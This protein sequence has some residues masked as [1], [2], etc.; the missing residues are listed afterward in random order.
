L[1]SQSSAFVR[2]RFTWLAYLMLAY[3][4]YLQTSLGPLMPFLRAELD[5]NYSSAGLHFSAFALGMILAG[6]TADR[7]VRRWGRRLVFWGG[8]AGMAVSALCLGL[9][10]Q[11]ALT[12]A[13]AF[14]MGWLGANLVVVIQATLSDRHGEQ[15]AVALTE[16]NLAASL[17][18]GLVPLFIGAFQRLGVGWRGALVLAVLFLALIAARFLG[19][20]VPEARRPAT[21]PGSIGQTLPVSFWAYWIVLF[22]VVS[23]EWCLVFW[24]ADFLENTVGLSRVSAV[25]VMSMFFLAMVMGRYTGSHLTRVMPGTSLLLI[26]LGIS[27]VGF[28]IFWLAPLAPVNLAGLFIAG[29]GVANLFPLTMATAV[30]VASQH[31]NVASARVSLGAGLAIL[32]APLVLGWTAD[33]L[34]I[35][36]AYGIVAVLLVGAIAVAAVTNRQVRVSI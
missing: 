25:T 10:R 9:S 20:E 12:I 2:D 5:L 22:L 1:L 3:F 34:T 4:A 19:V 13:S 33:Q 27:L 11:A 30:G 21:R 17:S 15:R 24:G 36:N 26:A 32:I 14:L 29:F 23:V 31:S 28:P 16:S 8:G 7:F 35:R 18:A 6:L